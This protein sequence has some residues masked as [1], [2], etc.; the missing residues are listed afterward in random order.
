MSENSPMFSVRFNRGLRR[1][2]HQALALVMVPLA[3]LNG[4]TVLNCGCSGKVMTECHCGHSV[5]EPDAH[6]R[7]AGQC[8]K[9]AAAKVARTSPCCSTQHSAESHNGAPSVGGHHCRSVAD[10]QVLPATT[11]LPTHDQH[12]AGLDAIAA[13]AIVV[14]ELFS[15]SREL[16]FSIAPHP[17]NDLVVVLHRLV[18]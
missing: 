2:C 9:C 5:L 3:V 18:I 8:P 4:H 1:R 15:T 16:P 6:R 14:D 11:V 10:F 12:V 13:S 17:P 7:E